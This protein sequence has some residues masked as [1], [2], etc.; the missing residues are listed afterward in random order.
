MTPAFVT[1]CT[2][3]S[4][5][6]DGTA[7][8]LAALR[9]ETTGLRGS[10]FQ[11]TTLATF[12]G[13]VDGLETDGVAPGFAAYDCR[14]NRL[15]ERALRADDFADVAAKARAVYGAT[16]VGV[17]VGTT[18]SGILETEIA[19][20]HRDAVTGNLPPGIR[21]DETFNLYSAAAYVRERLQLD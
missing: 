2:L 11:N 3:V 13:R 12:A 19:Y 20:R 14:N 9:A 1:R 17:F 18:S 8:T 10:D 6:G 21:F 16:R 15:A 4:A 5:V 7:A